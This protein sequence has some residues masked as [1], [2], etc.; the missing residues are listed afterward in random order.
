ME[1]LSR[2]NLLTDEQINRI[3]IAFAKALPALDNIKGSLL[4]RDYAYWNILGSSD[5]IEGIIDWDDCVSGD[6]ADDFGIVNCF[7]AEPLVERMLKSYFE[8]TQYDETFSMRIHLHTVRNMLWKTVIRDY[9]G[10]F[11]RG[12]GFFLTPAN[13]RSLRDYTLYKLSSELEKLE[14]SL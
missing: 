2:H 13:G 6:P 11:D 10:Y 5:R 9:M 1:Y 14:K 8:N 3:N 7:L 12:Q 4:H